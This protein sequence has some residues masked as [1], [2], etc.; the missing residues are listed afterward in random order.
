MKFSSILALA[1]IAALGD[2]KK[3]TKRSA[4]DTTPKNNGQGKGCLT[5]GHGE[6]LMKKWVRIFSGLDD[7]GIKESRQLLDDNFQFFSQS[8]WFV[9]PNNPYIGPDAHG[10]VCHDDA[11]FFL[12]PCDGLVAVYYSPYIYILHSVY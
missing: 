3:Y 9:T 4:P 5:Q 7:A 6:E 8:Q 12:T 11:H 2:A 10:P 1:S